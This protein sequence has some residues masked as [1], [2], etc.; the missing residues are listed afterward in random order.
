MRTDTPRQL[1]C[2]QPRRRRVLASLGA[3]LLGMLGVDSYA[4]AAAAAN[5]PRLSPR[6][7]TVASFGDDF[8]LVGIGVSR[9]GRVFA[10]APSSVK[11]SHYSL[12]EVDPVSG[13]MTPFPDESWNTYQAGEPGEHEWI[14]VQ[15]LWVDEDDHLWALDSSL[16]SVDQKS[17]PPKLVQF[18]LATRQILRQFNY[19][20]LVTPKDSHNDIRVDLMHGY[21]T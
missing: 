8:R 21:G 2:Q 16:P 5:S 12:V 4:I 18:D 17:Q 11:R 7:E 14:S 10:T 9:Q 1:A 15:A 20:E 3:A 13:T 6:L 19:G